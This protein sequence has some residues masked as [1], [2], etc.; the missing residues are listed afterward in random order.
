MNDASDYIDPLPWIA[1]F[2]SNHYWSYTV[3]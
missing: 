2:S 1:V 3:H